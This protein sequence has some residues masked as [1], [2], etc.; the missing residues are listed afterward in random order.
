MA[1]YYFLMQFNFNI[2]LIAIFPLSMQL[3]K[4]VVASR[5]LPCGTVI[6]EDMI[7]IKVAVTKGWDPIHFYNLIGKT[8]KR[9]Y[10]KE[11]SIMPAD[12]L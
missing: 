10:V 11:E 5:F 2:L 12:V 8:V 4:T 7:D 1:L 6:E 9:D 3:G